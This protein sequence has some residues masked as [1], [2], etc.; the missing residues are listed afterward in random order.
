MKEMTCKYC[1]SYLPIIPKQSLQADLPFSVRTLSLH[2]T[3]FLFLD[4]YDKQVSHSNTNDILTNLNIFTI[5]SSIHYFEKNSGTEI[6]LQAQLLR[7]VTVNIKRLS[8]LSPSNGNSIVWSGD[9]WRRRN[10]T[11]QLSALPNDGVAARWR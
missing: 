10:A 4:L 1:F 11:P 8:Y 9:S 2:C 7:T 3:G 6:F 5:F